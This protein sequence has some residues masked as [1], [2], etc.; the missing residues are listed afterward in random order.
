MKHFVES[1]FEACEKKGIPLKDQVNK[2]AKKLSGKASKGQKDKEVSSP[3]SSP[4]SSSGAEASDYT[5]D[6]SGLHFLSDLSDTSYCS[7]HYQKAV[8]DTAELQTVWDTLPTKNNEKDSLVKVGI[9]MPLN[10]QYT[11]PKPVPK[12]D[13][14]KKPTHTEQPIPGGTSVRSGP[15]RMGYYNPGTIPENT[16]IS[17]PDVQTGPRRLNEE[18]KTPP[19]TPAG[20]ISIPDPGHLTAG[21]GSALAQAF[22]TALTV[23]KDDPRSPGYLKSKSVEVNRDILGILLYEEN[24]NVS[25]P[26]GPDAEGYLK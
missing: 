4:R 25:S 15:F 26:A 12:E 17:Q 14:E 2:T 21:R 22:G 19:D 18:Y 9:T 3:K 6:S 20:N 23:A 11:G 24:Q 7:H 16:P 10:I 5:T 8:R 13:K 1:I